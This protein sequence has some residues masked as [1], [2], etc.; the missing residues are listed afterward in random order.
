MNI[1]TRIIAI[2]SA[3]TCALALSGCQTV[4]AWFGSPNSAPIITAAVDVAVATA[5]QKGVQAAQINSIAKQALAADS[6][7]SA[8][9]ATVASVV[10]AQL[11][12]LNLPAGDL[13]AANILEVA[14]GAAIEAKIGNN[15]SVAQAQAAVAQVLNAVIAATGG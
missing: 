6:G 2:A 3:L 9:L 10:N 5:E 15:A 1:P 13:A 11:A 7:V 14:I 12:K 8:T 4:S